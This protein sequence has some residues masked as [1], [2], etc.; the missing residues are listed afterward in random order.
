MAVSSTFGTSR[1][2]ISLYDQR[3]LDSAPQLFARLRGKILL[4]DLELPGVGVVREY[5]RQ[6]TE[7]VAEADAVL[8]LL[9]KSL[10]AAQ[11]QR[12]TRWACGDLCAK[13]PMPKLLPDDLLERVTNTLAAA[14]QGLSLAELQEA[15]KDVVSRRSLQ[16]RLDV[17]ARSGAIKT[18]EGRMRSSELRRRMLVPSTGHRVR[19]AFRP[20]S[21]SRFRTHASCRAPPRRNCG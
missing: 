1:T 20:H 14:P 19:C 11:A 13:P 9:E 2:R 4:A 8:A 3:E 5:L 16:R 17:W 10:Q 7:R 15:L 6:G 21:M 12:R 18:V